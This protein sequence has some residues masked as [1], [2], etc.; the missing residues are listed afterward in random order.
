M[1][2]LVVFGAAL[3]F[4]GATLA[5]TLIWGDSAWFTLYAVRGNLSFSNASEHPFY[6]LVSRLFLWLPGDPGRNVALVS[7]V[8]AALAVTLAYRVARQ[9]GVSALAAAVGAGALAVSHGFWLHAVIPEVY[10]ANACFLLAVISLVLAWSEHGRLWVLACAG[11]V[12]LVGLTNHLVLA[13]AAPALITFVAISRPH[14]F[15]TRRALLSV[16]GGIVLCAVLVAVVPPVSALAYKIWVGPPG[17]S[18]YFRLTFPVGPMLRESAYYVMYLAYQF[19]TVTLPVGILGIYALVRDRPRHAVLLLLLV[20][21]NAGVFIHHT[22][23]VSAATA[24]FVFYISDYAVFALF[25]AVGA[26]EVMRLLRTSVSPSMVRATGL[27]VLVLGITVP[28]L[29][30]GLLPAVSTM[31]GIDLIQAKTVPYRDNQQ[32][33]LNPNKHG[34]RGARRFAEEALRVVPPEAVIFADYTPATVLRYLQ[35][36]EGV[37]RDV[38]LRVA[39]GKVDDRVHVTWVEAGG[40]RRPV[41]VAT[42]TPDYYDFSGLTGDYEFVP[43]GPI[44]EVRARE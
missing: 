8:F 36:A 17:I 29:L 41:F 25:C 4:Y 30:Y 24:K 40:V 10:T 19:P 6:L 1:V 31:Y 39:D 23:W 22:A 35:L 43:A 44:F 11:L 14:L 20:L 37:R 7:A 32:Y 16:G 38:G 5:P 21:V 3:A 18:D 12:W 42:M 13:G 33:F 2:L 28:P 34:Y 26:E 9:L 15:L 27:A